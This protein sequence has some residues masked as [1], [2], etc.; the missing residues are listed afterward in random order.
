MIMQQKLQK[1]LLEG[2]LRSLIISTQAIDFASNDYLGLA[3]SPTLFSMV[4]NE[5]SLNKN[6]HI[7]GSTGS[8]LLTGNTWYAQKVERQIA[9][10]HSYDAALLY[11]CGYMANLGLISAI[12]HAKDTIFFDAHIHASTHN[13]ITLSRAKAFAFRHNDLNH[14]E[15]RLKN[16][17]TTQNRYI[18]IESIYSINGSQ[19]PL[20]DVCFLA[21]KYNAK[22]ILDEA[23]ATGVM[24]HSG[25][26]IVKSQQ[27]HPEIIAK[28]V[29]FSKAL[30]TLGAAI[31]G[32]KTLKE[33]LINFS[34]SFI[35]TTALPFYSLVAIK[36][37]YKLLPTLEKERQ[38]LKKLI[39]RYRQEMPYAS[40]TTIQPVYIKNCV[41]AKKL[42][43]KLK[44]HGF[45]VRA[46]LSP[47]VQRRHELLRIN[48][49]AFNREEDIK[50][51]KLCLDL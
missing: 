9:K 40:G 46:I 24:G 31:L 37:A 29:T 3:R 39:E 43:K 21:K 11:N 18:C 38:Q 47:T 28:V 44:I 6:K 23:H 12:A 51:F 42:S 45:D 49:H 10:F 41:E 48:L 26:G 17:T 1:R 5:I 19:V 2:N 20:K 50:E 4:N 33:F 15:K 7:F 35:Y 30:G 14:L 36:C 27:D 32:S 16:T 8:R 34:H 22:I 25:E 13:G